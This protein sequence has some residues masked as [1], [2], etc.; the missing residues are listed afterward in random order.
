MC[1]FGGQGR[2]GV[3]GIRLGRRQGEGERVRGQKHV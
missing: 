1:H 2:E 3:D